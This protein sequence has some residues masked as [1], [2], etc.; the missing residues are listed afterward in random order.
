MNEAGDHRLLQDF[1]KMSI[2]ATETVVAAILTPKLDGNSLGTHNNLSSNSINGNSIYD[3]SASSM[4]YWSSGD[5][6]SADYNSSNQLRYIFNGTDNPYQQRC[7]EEDPATNLTYWNLTCDTP[8]EYIVPLYG[9]FMPFLLIITV[10][11]NSLIVLVLSKKNMAT[12]TNFV[13]MGK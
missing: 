6:G 12:P 9:Y 8:L 10:A 13:L 1:Q 7:E 2:A 4:S 3:I 11:A 5:A